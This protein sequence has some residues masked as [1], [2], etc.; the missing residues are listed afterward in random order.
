KHLP[1]RLPLRKTHHQ[2]QQIPPLRPGH[3]RTIRGGI[4]QFDRNHRRRPSASRH[5]KRQVIQHPT[6]N[7]RQ[8]LPLHRW[9][10]H[11]KSSR[12]HQRRNHIPLPQH[13]L[14]P[15]HQI[16]RANRQRNLQIGKR[17]PSNHLHQQLL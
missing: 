15:P 4:R 11:R 17:R 3:G 7:Q 5:V 16:H 14:P 9:Q 2:R 6:V 12:C 10:Q 13:H 8:P 1:H